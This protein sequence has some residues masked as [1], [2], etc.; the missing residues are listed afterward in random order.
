MI[1]SVL[2]K[3]EY[4]SAQRG[5]ARS[6]HDDAKHVELARSIDALRTQ[7]VATE[8]RRNEEERKVRSVDRSRLWVEKV[9]MWATI[10]AAIAALITLWFIKRSTDA[11]TDAARAAIFGES[12][13]ADG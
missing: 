6:G 8:Q 11:A 4:P 2:I 3:P 1:E 5:G 9:T 13:G 7:Y 12:I 10:G